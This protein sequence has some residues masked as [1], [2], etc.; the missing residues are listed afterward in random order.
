MCFVFS[1]KKAPA[2]SSKPVWCI[3]TSSRPA[4]A[5]TSKTKTKF[6]S[7]HI[8]SAFVLLFCT[9]VH[10]RN[11]C[12]AVLVC[13][14]MDNLWWM[15]AS[16]LIRIENRRLIHES[17]HSSHAA[18][19]L[20]REVWASVMDPPAVAG[21][22]GLRRPLLSHPQDYIWEVGSG[23]WISRTE[24]VFYQRLLAQATSVCTKSLL[25]L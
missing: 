18:I 24:S 6:Y 8:Y 21:A 23:G 9:E 14:C 15:M 13:T 17:L 25:F 2:M 3:T 16:Y 11:L 1:T 5:T 19:H 4:K 22:P 7:S 20:R 12:L 10:E